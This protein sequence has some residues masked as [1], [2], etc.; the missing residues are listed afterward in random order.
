MRWFLAAGTA[1]RRYLAP[2]MPPIPRRC[3]LA[4]QIA[5]LVSYTFTSPANADKQ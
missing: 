1:V 5:L 4:P 2:F 3:P